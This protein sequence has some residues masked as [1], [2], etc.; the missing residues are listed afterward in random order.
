MHC[1]DGLIDPYEFIQVM[2]D[3]EKPNTKQLDQLKKKCCTLL[4]HKY[5]RK[6]ESI[7]FKISSLNRKD[8]IGDGF[9]GILSGYAEKDSQG[10]KVFSV[11]IPFF[12][13]I[14]S[15]HYKKRMEKIDEETISPSDFC[16][17]VSNLPKEFQIKK[18]KKFFTG[19]H[20][21]MTEQEGK[22]RRD[23]KLKTKKVEPLDEFPVKSAKGE[24]AQ[25][26]KMIKIIVPHQL[27]D[28]P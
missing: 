23:Q 22:K 7:F 4:K 1:A 27:S 10:I 11:I 2:I 3:Y 25:F 12:L 26:S 17:L 20:Q 8:L 21:K 9:H 19:L 28:D 13:F 15:W 16:I 5:C 14:V 6:C 24:G 18:L